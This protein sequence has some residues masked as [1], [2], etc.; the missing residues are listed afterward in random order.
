MSNTR[1]SKFNE[2]EP[3]KVEV[4][5]QKQNSSSSSSESKDWRPDIGEVMPLDIFKGNKD[6]ENMAWQFFDDE[7]ESLKKKYTFFGFPSSEKEIFDLA[8]NAAPLEE[9]KSSIKKAYARG[10]NHLLNTLVE[11]RNAA[12]KGLDVNINI[13]QGY[14][15]PGMAETITNLGNKL[16]GVK[17]QERLEQTTPALTIESEKQKQEREDTNVAAI[18]QVFDAIKQNNENTSKAIEEFKEFVKG[19]DINP[20]NRLHL[21][22]V[23]FDILRK[24]GGELPVVE[25]CDSGQWRGTLAEK[26]GNMVVGDAIEKG[27]TP[28][29]RQL[30]MGHIDVYS[31]CHSNRFNYCNDFAFFHAGDPTRKLGKNFYYSDKGSYGWLHASHM[32]T[33]VNNFLNLLQEITSSISMLCETVKPSPDVPRR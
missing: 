21:L 2:S 22:Y 4:K 1:R 8:F 15:L 19:R 12:I 32:P 24:R 13:A 16:Y 26:F 31:L 25:D 6:L 10:E 7:C 14:V 28:R 9:V 17:F 18:H 33:T 23:A 3:S 27:V 30:L 11:A 20:L 5:R 29:I